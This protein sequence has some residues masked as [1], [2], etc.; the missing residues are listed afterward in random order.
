VTVQYSIT[1]LGL[2]LTDT[3]DALRLWAETHIDEV[4]AAQ[5]RFD[6][7]AQTGTL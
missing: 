3:V 4:L 7:R 2:M 1:D 6:G 5:C